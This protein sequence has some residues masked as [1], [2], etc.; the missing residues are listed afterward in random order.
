[1]KKL[2]I[3]W[4]EEEGGSFHYFSKPTDAETKGFFE[5]SRKKR[6]IEIYGADKV[7]KIRPILMIL[8]EN[9]EVFD[10]NAPPDETT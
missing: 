5:A 1:M 4:T 8:V 9:K 3:L 6:M 7:V 10:F 2:H